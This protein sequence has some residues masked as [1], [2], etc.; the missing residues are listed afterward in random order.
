M[1]F[2]D[3]MNISHWKEGIKNHRFFFKK[4]FGFQMIKEEIFII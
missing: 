1:K 4:K 3:E 2:E